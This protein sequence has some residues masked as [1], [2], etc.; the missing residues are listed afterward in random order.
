MVRVLVAAFSICVAA[1]SSVNPAVFF[2]RKK[3]NV[4][5]TILASRLGASARG[6]S[7]VAVVALF[8]ILRDEL[9][10]LVA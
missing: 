2:V 4:G 5:A 1:V 3:A 9:C 7:V 10:N 6:G 8:A